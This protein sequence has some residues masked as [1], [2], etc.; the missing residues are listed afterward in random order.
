MK[1]RMSPAVDRGA[2]PPARKSRTCCFT[3]LG[4]CS[5]P[6]LAVPTDCAAALFTRV[7]RVAMP[8]LTPAFAA[9]YFDLAA[10]S[11][12]GKWA[13]TVP[14]CAFHVASVVSPLDWLEFKTEVNELSDWPA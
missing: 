10:A 5:S 1:V 12:T 7:L 13:A 2:L 3:S 6:R 11:V 8:P 9:L 14:A 4:I